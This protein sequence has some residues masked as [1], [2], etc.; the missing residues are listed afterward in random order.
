ME[1]KS[2]IKTDEIQSLVGESVV[3]AI[4]VKNSPEQILEFVH[5]SRTNWRAYANG[6]NA[7]CLALAKLIYSEPLKRHFDHYLKQKGINDL[8]RI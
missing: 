1:Q 3:R 2:S 8:D 7:E 5:A 6:M 4:T